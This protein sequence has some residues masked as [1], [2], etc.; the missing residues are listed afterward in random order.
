MR[1]GVTDI[2][3]VGTGEILCV[4]GN[5]IAVYR[6]RTSSSSGQS[7]AQLVAGDR[8]PDFVNGI[9]TNA[10]FFNPYSITFDMNRSTLSTSV[11]TATTASV[12]CNY[13]RSM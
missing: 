3:V 11:T 13:L 5:A 6:V 10:R 4:A 1:T 12:R 8:P 9:G 7:A 2:A